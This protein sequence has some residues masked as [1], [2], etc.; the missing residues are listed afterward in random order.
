MIYEFSRNGVTKKLNE[1]SATPANLSKLFKV[2]LDSLMLINA[3][4][5]LIIVEGTE[6]CQSLEDGAVYQVDG[7][8]ISTSVTTAD[9]ANA[10]SH[11]VTAKPNMHLISTHE[12]FLVNDVHFLY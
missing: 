2:S 12:Q 4:G 1:K 8:E 5:D 6:F 3:G 11:Q 10:N 9:A 7:D